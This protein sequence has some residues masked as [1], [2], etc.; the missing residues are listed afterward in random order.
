M[1]LPILFSPPF[2]FADV[3]EA[4]ILECFQIIL[5]HVND[6]LFI[7]LSCHWS[8]VVLTHVMMAYRGNGGI[9]L[10][11]L[12][13]G[14]RW[15]YVVASHLGRFTPGGR[16]TGTSSLGGWLGGTFFLDVLEKWQFCYFCWVITRDLL[17][18]GLALYWLHHPGWRLVY[19]FISVLY[20]S[21]ATSYNTR[22][23]T[24]KFYIF[25]TQC[26]YVFCM[27]LSKQRFVFITETESVYCA[28]RFESLTRV[29]DNFR[30]QTFCEG[31]FANCGPVYVVI[32]HT[33]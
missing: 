12:N 11:V 23:N 20:T 29:R 2:V 6:L 26:I 5:L 17:T 25:P 24:K 30:L 10:L 32:P 21:T 18:R 8:K 7:V 4:Q 27:H 16:V 33:A 31:A 15:R 13:L 9:A 28:V 19:V 14:S 22:F 3:P 1:F